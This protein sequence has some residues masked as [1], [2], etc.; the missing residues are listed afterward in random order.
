[1]EFHYFPQRSAQFSRDAHALIPEMFRENGILI[2]AIA[3]NIKSR[4]T[5][6]HGSRSQAVDGEIR[7]GPKTCQRLQNRLSR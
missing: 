5:C 3:A 6:R 4:V 1:M 7:D 2:G